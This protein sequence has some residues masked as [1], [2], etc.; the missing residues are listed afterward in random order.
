M[1]QFPGKYMLESI[2]SSCQ[3]GDLGNCSLLQLCLSLF[4]KLCCTPFI[5]FNEY[6]G[7]LNKFAFFSFCEDYMHV[8][9]FVSNSNKK[10][11]CITGTKKHGGSSTVLPLVKTKQMGQLLTHMC[12]Q[13]SLH[14]PFNYKI[15][16]LDSPQ[17]Q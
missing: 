7:I 13:R 8:Y 9:A 5:E 2:I 6:G 11:V 1:V 17:R 14:V 12:N 15:E 16:V 4:S 10:F 3:H